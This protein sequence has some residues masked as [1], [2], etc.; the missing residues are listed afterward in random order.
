[1][2][3]SHNPPS[4]SQVPSDLVHREPLQCAS[5]EKDGWVSARGAAGQTGPFKCQCARIQEAAV[6]WDPE[7]ESP[8]QGK[9]FV[10]RLLLKDTRTKH[11]HDP[12]FSYNTQAIILIFKGKKLPANLDP[13]AEEGDVSDE[14]T[15]DEEEEEGEDD[16][17]DSQA[18]ES[19]INR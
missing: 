6:P 14:D 7:R 15:G 12:T 10:R 5:A 9:V 13:D 19:L 8:S 1:M 17:D 11:T 16:N 18:N 2:K 4:A 3:K